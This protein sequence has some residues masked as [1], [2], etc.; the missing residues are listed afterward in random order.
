[1]K[2]MYS[3]LEGDRRLN[4]FL[5][6]R[7]LLSLAVIVSHVSSAAQGDSDIVIGVFSLGTLAVFGFFAISGYLVTPGLLRFG[8][9]RYFVNRLIRIY[10]GY[11]FCVA[12]TASLFFS[13]WRLQANNELISW[14]TPFSY[15]LKNLF[16]F[17]QGATSEGSTWNDLGGLPVRGSHPGMVNGSIWTLP[18]ELTCY[19]TLALFLIV[20]RI[21]S[22]HKTKEF[23]FVCFTTLWLASIFLA[24]KIP[25]ISEPHDSHLTQLLTKWPYFLA[26]SVG[27]LTRL[28]YKTKL[29]K[30]ISI[31]FVLVAYISVNN[32]ILWAICG[33]AVFSYLWIQFG[34]S[35][36][37]T[38]F[39]SFRDISYGLY[40]Y[41][42]PVIQILVN[43]Q[44]FYHNMILLFVS[45]IVVTGLFAYVS[46]RLIEVPAQL[47]AKKKFGK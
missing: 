28:L 38:R 42:V 9:K 36:T 3:S 43:Y 46:S 23:F 22:R 20:V 25:G 47:F 15:F 39:S 1:M 30:V 37:F 26:F 24:I 34:E 21:T 44:I 45:T 12:I 5:I 31:T 18:L 40:L 6:L 33:C 7:I 27:V 14:T 16:L 19:L 32:L 10:P 8:V 11:L 41:H 35:N 17:P 4:S 2:S 29:P 13:I